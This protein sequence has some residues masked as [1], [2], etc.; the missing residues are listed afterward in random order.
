MV[1]KNQ[2]SQF[3]W[4]AQSSEHVSNFNG[5]NILASKMLIHR[6]SSEIYCL[7]RLTLSLITT[8]LPINGCL[9]VFF[10]KSFYSNIHQHTH[11]NPSNEC[12]WYETSFSVIFFGCE[13]KRTV[14]TILYWSVHRQVFRWLS[15]S[16][17]SIKIFSVF[18]DVSFR[19]IQFA[20]SKGGQLSFFFSHFYCRLK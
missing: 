8:R 4:R 13:K 17:K 6:F 3:G 1:S 2:K 15:Q 11:T 20:H 7:Y 19:G 14:R 16:L 18:F 5:A 12:S 9:K 10:P